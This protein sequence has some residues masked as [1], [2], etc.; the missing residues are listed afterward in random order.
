MQ[1]HLHPWTLLLRNIQEIRIDAPKHSLVRNDNDVL[2]AL[3][4]HDN[5]LKTDNHI[6]IRLAATV[7]VVVFIVVAGLEVFRVL[8]GDL[9]V[10]QTVAD[11]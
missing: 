10:G 9:L 11:T 4:F 3:Q 6:P 1:G 2:T 7:A 5:R 8:V